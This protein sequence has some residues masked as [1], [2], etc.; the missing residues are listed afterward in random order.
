M[1]INLGDTVHIDFEDDVDTS[2]AVA[3]MMHHL[4]LAVA[5]FEAGPEGPL[6]YQLAASVAFGEHLALPCIGNFILELCAAYEERA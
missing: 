6:Y 4:K 3:L 2:G 1:N 5:Y